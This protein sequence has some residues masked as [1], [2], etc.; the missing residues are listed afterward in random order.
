LYFSIFVVSLPRSPL[1]HIVLQY[2]S[3]SAEGPNLE[4]LYSPN[5]L[6]PAFLKAHKDSDKIK[7]NHHVKFS[8]G[9]QQTCHEQLTFNFYEVELF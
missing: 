9:V 3:S 4:V 1:A 8:F 5:K 2:L 6:I 7:T